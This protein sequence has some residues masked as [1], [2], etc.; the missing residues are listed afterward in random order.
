MMD[1]KVYHTRTW[2]MATPSSFT[3]YLCLGLKVGINY[4]GVGI[5]LLLIT[6]NVN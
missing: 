6:E 5:K 3:S 4:R 1:F 2:V